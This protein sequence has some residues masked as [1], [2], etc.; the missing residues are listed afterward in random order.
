MKMYQVLSGKQDQFANQQFVDDSFYLSKEKAIARMKELFNEEE[1]Y[2]NRVEFW[3]KDGK[4]GWDLIS[5]D[6]FT[7]A[8]V[9]EI[10]VIGEG[11]ENKSPKYEQILEINRTINMLMAHPDN[12]PNSEFADRID[13]LMELKNQLEN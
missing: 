9:R 6:R 1:L 8:E 5:W 13:S 7:L 10:E 4:W 12:E 2:G 3:Q 11:I